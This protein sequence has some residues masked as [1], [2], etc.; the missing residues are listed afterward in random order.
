MIWQGDEEKQAGENS[1]NVSFLDYFFLSLLHLC[2]HI[3]GNAP[4]VSDW[5]GLGDQFL[6]HVAFTYSF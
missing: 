4:S 6:S 5:T 3:K 2:S 1:L